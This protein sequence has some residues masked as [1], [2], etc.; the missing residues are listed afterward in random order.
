MNWNKWTRQFHRWVAI[1]FTGTVII[2]FAALTQNL[3]PEDPAFVVFYVPLLPL[4]LLM[5]S[6]LYLF[7]LPY[8]T[9]WRNRRRIARA[10]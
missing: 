10:S 7:A 1:T 3:T 9:R 2:C 4:A 6:G 8:T 5:F